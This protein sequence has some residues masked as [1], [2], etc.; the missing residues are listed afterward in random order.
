[1]APTTPTTVPLALTTRRTWRSVAPVDSSMPIERSRRC[2]STVKPPTETSAMSSMPRTSAA[3]EIVSGLSGFDCATEA[4]VCTLFPIEL[5]ETPGR[6]EE[7]RDPRGILHLSG[8]DEGELVEEALRVLDDA[9]HL[10]LDAAD[11][12]GVRRPLRWKSEATPLVTA[13]SSAPDG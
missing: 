2:A 8:H 4:G 9:D 5:S 1:M 10:A 6:V 12:P 13:T 7:R 3:R 11:A